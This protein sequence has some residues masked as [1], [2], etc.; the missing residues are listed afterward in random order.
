MQGFSQLLLEKVDAI[1]QQWLDA[2]I[3]DAKIKSTDGLSRPAVKDRISDI[4]STLA[5]LLNQTQE[6][7]VE[8]IAKQS[9]HHG[10]REQ[11]KILT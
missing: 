11:D 8:T 3:Q 10:F 7:D 1:A 4:L 2:V 6:S 5:T 9:W